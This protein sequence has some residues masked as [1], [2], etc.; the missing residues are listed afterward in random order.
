[1]SLKKYAAPLQIDILPSRRILA[2][3]VF[4]HSVALVTLLV[5]PLP[6][7]SKLVAASLIVAGCW[8]QLFKHRWV[9]VNFPIGIFT[10]TG[11]IRCAIWDS[12]DDWRLMV[13]HGRMC[14]AQLLGSSFVHRQLVVLMFRIDGHPWYSRRQSIVLTTDNLDQGVFRRLRVRLR[15]RRFEIGDNSAV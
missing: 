6:V 2:F 8:Y 10:T 5:L 14:E 7:I 13:G 1:M 9:P 15:L 3:L 12:D 4:S 11:R